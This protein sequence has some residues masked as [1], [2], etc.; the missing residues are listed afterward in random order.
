MA[1]APVRPGGRAPGG[2]PVGRVSARRRMNIHA[3]TGSRT[4]GRS[5]C[6]SA[7]YSMPGGGRVG[8]HPGGPAGLEPRLLRDRRHAG[9]AGAAA[10]RD[11][12]RR[13][14][15]SSTPR[16]APPAPGARRARTSRSPR[17]TATSAPTACCGTSTRPRSSGRW[18]WPGS[19]PLKVTFT[20]HL[21]PTRRG[22]LATV[23]GRLRARQDRPPTPRRRSSRF[24]GGQA[25]S[26]GPP[27]RRRCACTPVV[28]TNRVLLG[29]DAD[30]ERGVAVAFAAHRQ[31]GQGGGRAGGPERQPDAG[32]AEE[33]AGLLNLPG[34]AP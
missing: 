31:P 34:S 30:P 4:R 12:R 26:C 1:L 3:G 32:S 28:G 9:G 6:R 24:V 17:W 19:R 14:A 16:A 29:A 8:R 5:C 23:Y 21:L 20:P 25:R 33:T 11:H 10:R 27:S 18:R 2:R 22:I 13:T 15:S 7:C